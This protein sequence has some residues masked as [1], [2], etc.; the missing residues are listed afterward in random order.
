MLLYDTE[1]CLLTKA[2]EALLAVLKR[3]ILR[4]IFGSIC[5]NKDCRQR[6]YHDLY[7]LH[8][9]KTIVK[10]IKFLRIGRFCHVGRMQETVP[11]RKALDG[12]YHVRHR[13]GRQ[14]D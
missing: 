12:G 11:Y 5:V 13:R 3:K 1:A 9:D 6:F 14:S 10:R 4:K 8:T 2:D 7:E